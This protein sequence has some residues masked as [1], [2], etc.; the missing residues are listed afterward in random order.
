MYMLPYLLKMCQF[1]I[2]LLKMTN[3]AD[4]QRVALPHW[5]GLAVSVSLSYAVGR[6]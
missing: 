1:I 3:H 6:R 2:C 5:D 4:W